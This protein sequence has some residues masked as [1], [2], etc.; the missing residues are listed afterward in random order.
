MGSYRSSTEVLDISAKTHKIL[1]VLV[2]GQS[3]LVIMPEL[4]SHN[5]LVVVNS[6]VDVLDQVFPTAIGSPGGSSAA[7]LAAVCTVCWRVDKRE[8]PVAPAAVC[9]N[10]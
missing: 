7:A 5:G 2:K 6:L 10:S 3:L 4:H 8:E 1:A 9:G